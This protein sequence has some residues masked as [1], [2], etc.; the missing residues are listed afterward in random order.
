[1]WSW[2]FTYPE[3]VETTNEL[4]V[5]EGKPILLRMTSRD[6]VHALSLPYFRVKEDSMPGR[7]TYLWF[8]P[9]KAGEYVMTCTEFCGVLHSKM[10][11]TLKVLPKEEFDSW[12]SKR[13]TTLKGGV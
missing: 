9:K 2:N 1:M 11:G 12:L 3:G 6:V 8:Y 10:T 4:V 7:L 13:E 5:P